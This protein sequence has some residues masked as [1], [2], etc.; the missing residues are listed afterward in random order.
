[1]GGVHMLR[2]GVGVVGSSG[3][4]VGWEAEDKGKEESILDKWFIQGL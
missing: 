2:M 1:M 4:R 3:T